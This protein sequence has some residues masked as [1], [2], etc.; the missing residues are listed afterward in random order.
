M[1]RLITESRK[2][3]F[4]FYISVDE[5]RGKNVKK[6]ASLVGLKDSYDSVKSFMYDL[7]Q[8]L[9]ILNSYL[10]DVEVYRSGSVDGDYI[11]FFDAESEKSL[12]GFFVSCGFSN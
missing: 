2:I 7:K 3:N 8:M 10:G 11:E 6:A 9:E 1:R 4:E 5:I 12:G